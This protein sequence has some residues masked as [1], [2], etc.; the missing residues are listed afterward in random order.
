MRTQSWRKSGSNELGCH[1]V[2][3][4]GIPVS[5]Q[6]FD[7]GVYAGLP[8]VASDGLVYFI[9]KDDKVICEWSVEDRRIVRSMELK[10]SVNSAEQLI[11]AEGYLF[12]GFHLIDLF[13]WKYLTSFVSELSDSK[14]MENEWHI[15]KFSV[16]SSLDIV[17]GCFYRVVDSDS[18]DDNGGL[19]RIDPKTLDQE[20]IDYPLRSFDYCGEGLALGLN[21]NSVCLYSLRSKSVIWEYSFLFDD[22]YA[23]DRHVRYLVSGD[24]VIAFSSQGNVV[25]LGINDGC[26]KWAFS[27]S[28]FLGEKVPA[29]YVSLSVGKVLANDKV[30]VLTVGA[31]ITFT[32]ALSIDSGS[33]LWLEEESFYS[34]KINHCIAGDLLFTCYSE[35]EQMPYAVDCFTGEVVWKSNEPADGVCRCIAFENYVL[36][37]GVYF[38]GY[39]S[40]WGKPYISPKRKEF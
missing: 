9:D 2:L 34:E 14:L 24:R 40:E 32:L 38:Q 17:D 21:G 19:V 31:A 12:T 23:L 33:L 6:A 35:G 25:C 15:E 3:K 20:F 27:A 5:G 37:A 8:V 29:E 16:K 36:Y 10:G 11:V 4:G 26:V 39:V 1:S 28:D 13:E 22:D 7:S 30:V 18:K